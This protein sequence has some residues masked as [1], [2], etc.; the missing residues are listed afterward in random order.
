MF[1]TSSE[2]IQSRPGSQVRTSFSFKNRGLAGSLILGP[3]AFG[4]LFSAPRVAESEP[5]GWLL[6]AG[7]WVFF[8]LYVSI[9]TWATLFIGGNKDLQLQTDGPYSICRNPLYLGSFFF[10]IAVACMLKSAVFAAGLIIAFVFYL[11]FVVPAEE[12]FLG[13]RFGEGFS[14]YCRRTPR[15]WPRWSSLN[16]PAHVRVD[17]KRLKQEFIRL[18]RAAVILILL[19]VLM[20]LRGSTGW[21]HWF[22]FP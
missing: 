16:S 1:T 20:T 5:L 12:H 22:H 7:A 11:N 3:L 4:I 13:L 2:R 19:E 14:N 8:L 21:P 15:F 18:S 6:N 9:R 10:A 17:L